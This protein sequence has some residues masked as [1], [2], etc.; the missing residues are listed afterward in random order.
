VQISYNGVSLS[1]PEAIR[2]RY[3][4]QETDKDWHEAAAATPISYR[5]L[6]PAS[7]HFSVEA[8]DTNG[9]WSG[10]PTNLAFAITPA[11]YQT[12]WFRLLCVAAV[13]TFLWGLYQLRVQQL[14]GEERKLRETIETI[15]A[16][17]L[18]L[19]PDGAVQF[20]NRRWVEY[21]GLSQLGDA[22]GVEKTAIHPEDLD[23]I[24]RRLGASFASG[25]PYED[26]MRVR[27]SDGEYRWFLG[28]AVPLRDA[29]KQDRQVVRCGDRYSRSQACGR[30]A[31]GTCTHQSG[32]HDGRTGR[33]HLAR[34]RTAHHG[35]NQ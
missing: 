13:L 15:P 30:A 26:E 24:V 17:A 11:F 2:F 25:E 32:Q 1:D 6:P 20:R 35:D 7:Y 27:N 18:I 8:S 22:E 29:S 16:M 3:K 14:R 5:N 33:L 21:T 4:L 12:V 23:R 19:G 34:T 31:S 9:V 10:A 28:R